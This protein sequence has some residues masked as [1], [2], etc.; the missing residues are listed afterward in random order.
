M[1]LA[2]HTAAPEIAVITALMF[3][4]L[5]IL[6]LGVAYAYRQFA[7]PRHSLSSHE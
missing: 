6:H 4:A 1:H 2:P 3:F 7:K 5:G